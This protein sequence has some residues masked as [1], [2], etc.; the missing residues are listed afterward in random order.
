MNHAGGTR[1][2]RTRLPH[3]TN[4]IAGRAGRLWRRER[5]RWSRR[6]RIAMGVVA[7]LTSVSVLAISPRQ[8]RR[9]SGRW[10]HLYIQNRRTRTARAHP[11][12]P[13]TE[14]LSSTPKSSTVP[15]EVS[16][17][18][19]THRHRHHHDHEAPTMRRFR[20]SSTAMG[21]GGAS[22]RPAGDDRMAAGRRDSNNIVGMPPGVEMHRLGLRLRHRLHAFDFD[23][24]RCTDRWIVARRPRTVDDGPRALNAIV[25]PRG[26]MVYHSAIP[27]RR[28]RGRGV[29]RRSSL[30]VSEWMWLPG[31]RGAGSGQGGRLRPPCRAFCPL[32]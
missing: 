26:G 4:T 5:E 32:A 19:S 3:T 10:T 28:L 7:R 23:I 9:D 1:G 25:P 27:I 29:G 16:G 31:G 11:Q 12:S 22:P 15:I 20:F 2:G 30:S 21:A 17:E 8:N 24:A 14:R 18:G 13:T 6:R